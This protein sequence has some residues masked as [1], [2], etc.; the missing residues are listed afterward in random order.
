[1]KR[2]NEATQQACEDLLK[3]LT[4]APS[5]IMAYIAPEGWENSPYRFIFHPTA[6]QVYE[7]RMIWHE[8]EK[9]WSKDLTE[10]EDLDIPILADI[11]NELAEESK[12]IAPY[13]EFLDTIGSCLWCIFSNNHDVV[14]AKGKVYNL[15]SFRGSGGFIGDFLNKHYPSNVSFNYMDFYCAD[16]GLLDDDTVYSLLV[17]LF[18]RL[19]SKQLDW[20]YSFPQIGIVS[21]D[22]PESATKPE[23]YDPQKAVQEELERN[24][25]QAEIQTLQDKLDA[26]YEQEKEDALYKAPPLIIRAYQTVYGCFPVGWVN[27]N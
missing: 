15:G 18:E 6:Q 21:F 13:E 23:D 25:K 27:Q 11:E 16:M 3:Y 24:Q 14:D 2:P 8:N 12:P 9:S 1:M 19:K 26:I 7:K 17:L 20:N 22:K 4:D 10:D 5:T